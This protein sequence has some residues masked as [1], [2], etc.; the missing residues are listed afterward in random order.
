[1]AKKSNPSAKKSNEKMKQ[2]RERERD[3]RIR[4]LVSYSSD[5]RD[6]R[7]K[8]RKVGNRLQYNELEVRI[9]QRAG[10]KDF[11]CIIQRAESTALCRLATT[12]V[13]RD[14]EGGTSR[15]RE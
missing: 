4:M 15:K 10:S 6:R 3:E 7:E 14:R 11:C 1:M 5:E 12:P 2:E 8:T 13:L 9:F